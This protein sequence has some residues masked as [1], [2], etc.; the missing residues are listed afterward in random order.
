ML[1]PY[2]FV[3]NNN[4]YYLH[5]MIF[6]IMITDHFFSCIALSAHAQ[7]KLWCCKMQLKMLF[8]RAITVVSD[9]FTRVYIKTN[10][11]CTCSIP[12][13]F[14]QHQSIMKLKWCSAHL[15]NF[16]HSKLHLTHLSFSFE[17]AVSG[18]YLFLT[19]PGFVFDSLQHIAT[20]SSFNKVIK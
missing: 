8:L 6:L 5:S 10:P 3:Y 1:G 4:V 9:N 2:I 17:T 19:N 11:V 16:Y 12:R 7:F 13:L 20:H 15:K 14:H 18:A